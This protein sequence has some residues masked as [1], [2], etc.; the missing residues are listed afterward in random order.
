MLT[1]RSGARAWSTGLNTVRGPA[2]VIPIPYGT[3]TVI[4]GHGEAMS[5]EP[6]AVCAITILPAKD[7]L[8]FVH[9]LG[10]ASSCD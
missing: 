10:C 6:K 3:A 2:T 9:G 5:P 8:L 1:A 4:P 7:R